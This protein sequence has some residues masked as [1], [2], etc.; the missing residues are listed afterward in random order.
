MTTRNVLCGL[1]LLIGCFVIP[2][3]SNAQDTSDNPTVARED[4]T[5]HCRD[6]V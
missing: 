4:Q 5:G 1:V 6:R 3:T 2:S